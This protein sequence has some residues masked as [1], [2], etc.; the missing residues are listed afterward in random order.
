M[1]AGNGFV[2]VAGDEKKAN[3]EGENLPNGHGVKIA[4]E[5]WAGKGFAVV[6][7]HYKKTAVGSRWGG[8][9]RGYHTHGNSITIDFLLTNTAQGGKIFRKR[10]LFRRKVL[11]Q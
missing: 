9:G 1:N 6:G 11:P 10:D 2:R 5:G 4:R 3:D 7:T 8:T